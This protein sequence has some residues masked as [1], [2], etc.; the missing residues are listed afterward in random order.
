MKTMNAVYLAVAIAE[1]AIM[2]LLLIRVAAGPVAAGGEPAR[3]G[4]RHDPQ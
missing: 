2:G 4:I 3:P 1:V